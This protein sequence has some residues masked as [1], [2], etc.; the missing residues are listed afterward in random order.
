MDNRY[1][2]A[3]VVKNLVDCAEQLNQALSAA[4]Q[5]K[6]EKLFHQIFNKQSEL[7]D[8]ASDLMREHNNG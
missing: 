7:M 4:Q 5:A 3:K 6:N 8:M 1:Y 2:L